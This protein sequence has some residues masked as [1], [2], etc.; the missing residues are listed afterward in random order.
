MRT[1]LHNN[2]YC[3]DAGQTIIVPVYSAQILTADQIDEAAMGEL[4]L[5]VRD[6]DEWWLDNSE[7]A[8]CDAPAGHY[9]DN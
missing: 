4:T 8:I 1:Q 3:N 9:S 6:I 2:F 7:C 5:I